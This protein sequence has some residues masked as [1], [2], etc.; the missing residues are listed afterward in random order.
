[1][2]VFP[3]WLIAAKKRR[4]KAAAEGRPDS[5]RMGV[6]KYLRK[7]FLAPYNLLF[8]LAGMGAAA[9]SP[10]PDAALPL[11]MAAEMTYLA[12]LTAIPRFRQAVDAEEHAK[13]RG[14]AAAGSDPGQTTDPRL[15]QLAV[16]GMLRKLPADSLRRFEALR[17]RCL[18]MRDIGHRVRAQS[19]LTR[20]PTADSIRTPALDR[21][22]FLFLKLLVSQEGLR[23][24]MDSTSQRELELR[25]ED[26]RIRLATAQGATP[27]DERVI[28]SLQDS[29]AD[30]ELRVENYR[31]SSKDAEFIALELD[32]IETKI[33][34]LVEM[35][36]SQQDPD[37]LSA[38]VNAAAESM[39]YT[40]SA[41]SRL[42]HL[43]GLED[44]LESPP[45]ILEANLGRSVARER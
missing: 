25:A 19:A 38:Q 29:L 33:Q 17:R 39:Q 7:A 34:A 24:F 28:R 43:T 41:V 32:R 13:E 2:V 30:A 4:E 35:G 20:D 6:R 21:L 10:F 18:D 9:L 22:L 12:G 3:F 23:R 5:D 14:A 31:K 37:L 26:I 11:V 40:E 42:Q 44:Q 45:P 15:A 36:V 16:E 1:V 27:P 8:F